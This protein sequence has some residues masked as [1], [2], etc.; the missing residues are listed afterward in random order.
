MKVLLIQPKFKT[1][2]ITPPLGLGY[3]ASSLLTDGHNVKLLDCVAKNIDVI[4]EIQS[5]RPDFIGITILSASYTASIRLI[6]EIKQFSNAK[7]VIGGQHPTALPEQSLK[8][9]NADYCIIGEGEET[10]KELC[11]NSNVY[12]ISGLAINSNNIISF[13]KER[14]LIKDINSIPFPAWNLIKPEMYPPSPHGAFY[15]YFP[16]APIITTRGCPYDCL[17]CASKN[18]WKGKLRIRNASNVVDEIELL[19]KGYGIKEFHFEDDNLTF[20]KSHAMDICEEIVERKLKI[21]WACPNGVRIDKLDHELIH[22]MKRA[23]CYQLSFGIESG[24]QQILDSINKHLKL[25]IVP[26][27]IDQ[28]KSEGIITNGFFIIG[29][30]DD[31]IETVED[32]INFALKVP[33]DRVQFSRFMPLPGTQPFNEWYKPNF[34][35]DMINLVGETTYNSK[36]LTSKEIAELQQKAF[37]KFYFR[38]SVMLK[39]FSSIKLNQVIWLVKRTGDY[40]LW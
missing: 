33:F 25:E 24:N 19:N 10:F 4:R 32:T 12:S 3:L 36:Y 15:K 13:T 28:V 18:M 26:D 7:I 35:W 23:G 31:T 21:V 39:T 37:R 1:H 20:S 40:K 6:K 16:I 9:T 27:I 30:P 2:L 38:P 5:F 11:S 17:F 29:L 34:D 14:N 8:D 22:A